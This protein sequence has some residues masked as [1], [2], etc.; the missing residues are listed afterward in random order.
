M[1]KRAHLIIKGSRIVLCTPRRSDF[2]LWRRA[3]ED[4]HAHLEPW[5][6][7]WL[8]NTN[9]YEG[10]RIRLD[11]WKKAARHGT[12]H[13]FLIFEAGENNLLGGVSLT[14]IRRGAAQTGLLGYWLAANAEAK[15]YMSE[16]VQLIC[17]WA[18]EELGLCRIEAGTLPEN[19]RSRNVLERCGFQIEGTARS[20]LQIAGKRRDHLIYA[21]I[22]DIDKSSV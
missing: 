17:N 3:R 6:P 7:T 1:F 4:S 22:P 14:N 8:E 16:A 13:A 11:A 21:F 19:M 20:Y 15:G 10:W 2:A 5:K 9:S 12:G 18:Y